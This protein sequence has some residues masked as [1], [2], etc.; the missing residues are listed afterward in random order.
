MKNKKAKSKVQA[1]LMERNMKIVDLFNKIKEENAKP[2][3]KYMISQI[4]NGK[5]TEL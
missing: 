5:R 3:A 2:V 4:V 1:I